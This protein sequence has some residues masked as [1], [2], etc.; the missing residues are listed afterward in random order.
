MSIGSHKIK[1]F[2][3]DDHHIVRSGI[4]SEL[5]KNS[6]I[7]VLGEASSG[8][9]ALE[10]LEKII[11]DVILMDISMP[12][13]N[14]LKATEL[15]KKRMPNVKI[16][17]LTMHDNKNYVAELIRLGASGYI[18]KDSSPEEL[19]KAIESV[20][21]N[22]LYFSPK[23]NVDL[24]KSTPRVSRASK[25]HLPGSL[26]TREESILKFLVNGLSNKEIAK[27]LAIS[28]R[29]VETHREHIHRKLNMKSLAELTK[30]AISAGLIDMI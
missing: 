17:A 20:N 21:D 25:A 4:R 30:Y 14:G 27:E 13:M 7:S 29:T 3:V 24:I 11:P 2:L 19:V 22:E 16:I 23:I 26:T 10:K 28:V 18:M 8:K 15:I 12:E 1:V 9:D 5:S 6:N